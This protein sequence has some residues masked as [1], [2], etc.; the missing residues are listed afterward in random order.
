MSEQSGE[1]TAPKRRG[2][3]GSLVDGLGSWFGLP[4]TSPEAEAARL[5]TAHEKAADIY[6]RA[7]KHFAE[8]FTEVE[9]ELNVLYNEL[10][11]PPGWTPEQPADADSAE[12]V[13]PEQAPTAKEAGLNQQLP[14]GS[15]QDGDA[16]DQSDPPAP[17]VSGSGQ[18]KGTAAVLGGHNVEE[19]EPDTSGLTAPGH[20]VEAPAPLE[21][22][23]PN[24]PR[25]SSGPT[26]PEM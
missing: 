18:R 6:D 7:E 16:K 20:D 13:D 26:S 8:A 12:Q 10:G 11:P 2:V 25:R 4:D 19:G 21:T 15:T 24:G 9:R 17:K 23:A 5:R 1:E 14:D 3:W 22:Q